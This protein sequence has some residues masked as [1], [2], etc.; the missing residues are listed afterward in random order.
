[1]QKGQWVFTTN[2][3]KYALGQCALDA[4]VASFGHSVLEIEVRGIDSSL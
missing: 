2:V 1:M 3:E 4:D